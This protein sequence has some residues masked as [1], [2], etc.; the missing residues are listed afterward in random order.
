VVCD[1]LVYVHAPRAVR[2]RRLEEQRGWRA[3]EVQERENVQ[4]S[5]TDK[6]SRADYV[7]DNSGAPEW[8]AQQVD[9]LL[10]QWGIGKLTNDKSELPDGHR[11]NK[12]PKYFCRV[13]SRGRRVQLQ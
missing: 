10:R 7:V 6:V 3:R 1:W 9:D 4:M 13:T 5:L 12:A 11:T 8:V 2:L